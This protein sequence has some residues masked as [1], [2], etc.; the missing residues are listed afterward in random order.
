MSEHPKPPSIENT[1]LRV[2]IGASIVGNN[3]QMITMDPD[4]KK[5]MVRFSDWNDGS[6]RAC[7]APVLFEFQYGTVAEMV[8]DFKSK[9]ESAFYTFT[10]QTR[11][12]KPLETVSQERAEERWVEMELL[13]KLLVGHGWPNNDKPGVKYLPF[14]DSREVEK[15]E[16]RERL[17]RLREA[18]VEESA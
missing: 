9:L 7:D 3:D 4:C 13:Q 5:H 6:K 16:A 18:N 12:G 11:E 8:E 14:T 17:Q 2:V 10:Y 15:R 1:R